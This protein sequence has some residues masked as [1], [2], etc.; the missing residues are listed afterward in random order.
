MLVMSVLYSGYLTQG[1][2]LQELTCTTLD[3]ATDQFIETGMFLLL[4]GLQ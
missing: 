2:C 4:E 1:I 3:M